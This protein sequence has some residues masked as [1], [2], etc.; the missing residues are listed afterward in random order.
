MRNLRGCLWS[1][2]YLSIAMGAVP[3]GPAYAHL[4]TS[5]E[6][7]QLYEQKN[8]ANQLSAKLNRLLT[9]LFV[10][11]TASDAGRNPIEPVQAGLGKMLR[12]A[13]WNIERGI[14][15]DGVRYAFRHST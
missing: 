14:E 11:N 2:L 1:G 13:E 12:V 9:T 4:L 6:I 15:F 7:V 10:R 8:V 3:Q 5:D